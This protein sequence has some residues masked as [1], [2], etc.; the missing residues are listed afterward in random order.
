[1]QVIR[2]GI[3]GGLNLD[4]EF[5]VMPKHGKK[6]FQQSPEDFKQT[7]ANLNYLKRTILS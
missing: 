7:K 4:Q 5:A 1:M 3:E 6:I 2:D